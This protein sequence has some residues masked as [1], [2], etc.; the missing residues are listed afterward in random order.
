MP[1]RATGY[2][3]RP[4]RHRICR[5]RKGSKCHCLRIVHSWQI[6]VATVDVH[7]TTKVHAEIIKGFA[8]RAHE[9]HRR[10][11]ADRSANDVRILPPQPATLGKKLRY[12]KEIRNPIEKDL[13]CWAYGVP[14]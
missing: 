9:L 2:G 3:L 1:S 13:H 6:S 5:R 14:V 7:Q 11:V 4:K 10:F 8:K 12:F